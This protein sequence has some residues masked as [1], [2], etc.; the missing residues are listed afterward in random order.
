[1]FHVAGSQPLCNLIYIPVGK[2]LG[3]PRLL[4]SISGTTVTIDIENI[5]R[6]RAVIRK[7]N[8]DMGAW[9]YFTTVRREDLPLQEEIPSG[10]RPR[11][12]GAFSAW[13]FTGT[14]FE[15]QYI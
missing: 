4:V 6:R 7:Q 1:M 11:Y 14:F 5:G 13:F 12:Q 8:D 3:V 10:S 9:N 15:T 2:K